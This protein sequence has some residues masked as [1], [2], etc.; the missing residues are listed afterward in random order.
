MDKK[1]NKI[2]IN[3]TPTKIKN[4]AVA[5]VTLTQKLTHLIANWP[6][7]LAASCLNS[8]YMSS[9]ALIRIHY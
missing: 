3:L 7:F 2:R 8:G 1:P 9:Y 5:T 6:A 4:H